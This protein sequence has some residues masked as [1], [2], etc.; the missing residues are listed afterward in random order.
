[1]C[2][3]FGYINDTPVDI[4]N[5]R[6]LVRQSERRGR[7][8][9]G[10][11]FFEK[12]YS[13]V[14]SDYRATKLF[15]NLNIQKS[16]FVCGHSRLITN[17]KSDNQPVQSD[18]VWVLHNGIVVNDDDQWK[19]LK[20]PRNLEVDSEVIAA[21][22]SEF[23][24]NGHSLEMLHDEIFST[25]EGV[26]SSAILLK[27]LG[28]LCLI[29]NNGS[30][31]IGDHP[32]MGKVFASEKAFLMKIN[33][34]SIKQILNETLIIDVPTSEDQVTITDHRSSRKSMIPRLGCNTRESRLLEY[35]KH[36]IRRCSKC[37]L[38]E[39]M[40]FIEFDNAGVCNYCNSYKLRAPQKPISE[41]KENI[42]NLLQRDTENCIV[43]F[44]GGRDSC[45]ALHIIV[46]ELGLKPITYTYDWGMITDIGRRNI[47]RICG[48]LNVENI[49]FAADIEQKRKNIA[50]NLNAWLKA[51][52]LGMV[53]ILMAGDKHFF[54]HI[55]TVQKETGISLN[56]WGINPLETTH[57]KAGF[58]GVPPY[59]ADTQVYSSGLKRQAYYQAKR[60][61][62]MTQSKEYFNSSIFDTLSGE[63][64]R[65]I[66]GKT[67]YFH[68][69][70]YYTWDENTIEQL[71]VNEYGWELAK[72]TKS[73][74]RIGDGSASFYNYIY[75]TIAGLTEHDT[76]RSNQIR[77][78]TLT[79][80]KALKLV[81]DENKPRYPHIKW[82]LDAIGFDFAT[83]IEKINSIPK[84]IK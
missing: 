24:K 74:W 19:R 4:S 29:S 49:V 18:G 32:K 26:V 13:V 14:R 16:Q 28:K 67:D 71:L 34:K 1:M 83:V 33:C 47:S 72:D 12:N 55:K 43:P 64:Y 2:G 10:F 62:A 8:S 39:T 31:F 80:A 68:L 81:E 58:L 52:H 75:Y 76:F 36:N 20:T 22:A 59:L 56:I 21:I 15:S 61:K 38:P 7:D 82:Y 69:F 35:K 25:C 45:Y 57:F 73:S 78:G 63:L 54:R 37:I 53:N 30:L 84:M 11:I 77:E 23:V 44:S 48:K 41:L 60:F 6:G 17:G 70:D 51:P 79:R 50:M 40:P 46:K 42:S 5:L 3:I 27:A 65:S 66:L 9:S